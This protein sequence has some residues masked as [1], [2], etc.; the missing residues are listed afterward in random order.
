MPYF[1]NFMQNQLYLSS[2]IKKCSVR[3]LSKTLT[4]KCLT[5]NGVKTEVVHES[6]LTPPHVR[7]HFL[8]PVGFTETPV[9][10]SRIYD[11]SPQNHM[12]IEH[13]QNHRLRTVSRKFTG[14][15]NIFYCAQI[16]TWGSD[17]VMNRLRLA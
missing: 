9:G 14:C 10:Y 16:F 13:H 4:S 11:L 17:V 12:K 15:L 7:R 2:F 8:D 5:E 6:R 1:I 3:L